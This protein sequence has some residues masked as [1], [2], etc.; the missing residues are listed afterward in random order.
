MS[1]L[2][3]KL[4]PR[5]A[6]LCFIFL[7]LLPQSA[8]AQEEEQSAGVLIINQDQEQYPL[9]QYLEILRDT[10]NDLTIQEVASE[11]Y[12]DQWFTSQVDVPNFGFQTVPYWVR[13]RVKNQS[14]QDQEWVIAQGFK[15]THYMDLYI[16]EENGEFYFIKENGIFS[17]TEILNSPFNYL[18][19]NVD[20]PPGSEQIFYIRFKSEASMTLSL[21]LLSPE[22]YARQIFLNQL[23]LGAFYGVL[24]I[25]GLYN[26]FLYFKLREMEYLFLVLFNLGVFG[27][28]FFTDAMIAL[29]LP[30]IS[31]W[32]AKILILVSLGTLDFSFLRFVDTFLDLKCHFPKIHRLTNILSIVLLILGF[33]GLFISYTIIANILLFL[34]TIIAF[35]TLILNMHFIRRGQRQAKYLLL[36]LVF[37]LLGAILLNLTRQGYI[38]SNFITEEFQR[39]GLVWMVSFWSL[40]MADRMHTLKT[41]AERSQS[42]VE[43]NEKR[44]TQYLD[45][46]PF[47]VVVYD[48][49]FHLRYI[50]QQSREILNQSSTEIS[51]DQIMHSSLEETSRFLGF[52]VLNTDKSYPI[53]ELP[54]FR[55][56]QRGSPAYTDDLEIDLGDRKIPLE[57]WTNPLVDASGDIIGIVVAFQNIQE[58]LDQENL[59]RQSEEL[60]KKILEGS[61]IGTWMNNLISGEVIWD[62]RTREIFGVAFD[63]PASLD[64]GYSLIHPEDL[65]MAQDAFEQAISPLSNGAYEEEKRIIRP[66]GQERWIS[67]RGNVIFDE[68]SGVRQAD[69]MVGVVIDIT[70]QKLAEKALEESRIQYQKLI[71]TMNEGLGVADENAI[72]TY[73]NPRLAEMLKYQQ[74]EMVGKHLSEFFDQENFEIV[75][76]QLARRRLGQEQS[77]T[78]TWRC[79]DG[80]ELHTLVAP[81]AD[82]DEHGNFLRSI[83]VVSDITEQVKAN[84]LL[85][86]RMIE[87][88]QEITSLMEVSRTIVSPLD[89]EEQLKIILE[90]LSTVIKFDGASV[91]LHKPSKLIARTFQMQIPKDITEK[92]VQA[93]TQPGLIDMRFLHDEAIIF[94]N[95]RE[96]SKEA[97]SFFNLTGSIFSSVPQEM[98]S[99]MGVPIKSRNTLIGVLSV[100]NAQVDF[101]TPEMAKLM[102]AFANQIAI[103]FENQQLYRQ[104]QSLAAAGERDRLARELHDSVTQSL[105]SIRLYAEAVRSAL[106]AGQLPLIEKN[107][108]QL[109]SIARDGMSGL[110]LLIYELQ[111]PVLEE[112]GLIGALQKRLEMVENRAG[113]HSELNVNGKPDLSSNIETQLYWIAYEALSNVLKHAKAKNVSLNFDFFDETTTV[114]LQDDGVGFDPSKQR[115]SNGSGLKN[116]INRVE[117]FGGKLRID[118]KPGEGT[119]LRID[120]QH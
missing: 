16:P 33:S 41:E 65:E 66:D 102:Q 77:Y 95:I 113:I 1:V 30:I 80:C 106:K 43:E 108:D 83:A 73:V 36:S 44:L 61:S 17:A 32:W 81:A 50:N 68:E 53:E 71:E 101:F 67:T 75:R 47:G 115:Y 55:A 15:N 111:P 103:I 97:Q 31:P 42:Q 90:K 104:A 26:A 21:N 7:F 57:V 117:S 34:G 110:R 52:K 51:F 29:F 107:L 92:M 118:S 13:F 63:T 105:Y 93:F 58:R 37:F 48:A 4:L 12:Q 99:W 70:E 119:L 82:F 38:P 76:E 109:I 56:I 2:I 18:S 11:D 10:S 39:F 85:D 40:A 5:M 3:V 116:I 14:E 69:R 35:I 54:V 23:K 24:L 49:E 22:R 20:I 100:H 84:Q 79:K 89:F 87:R 88:T 8:L 46:M 98:V 74:E 19:F 91:L 86:Q 59:L 94:P 9:G 78:L 27:L 64:L 72:L 114:I 45:S 96:Q 120:I 28:Y 6:L 60:R 62:S 25:I 112:L